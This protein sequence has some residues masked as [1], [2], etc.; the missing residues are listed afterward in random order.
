MFVLILRNIGVF[1]V[2]I[3]HLILKFDFIKNICCKNIRAL[4]VRIKNA[5]DIHRTSVAFF[6]FD[7]S[8]V[9]H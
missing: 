2:N 9:P 3:I 7:E 6:Y 8:L 1:T 4:K 5:T